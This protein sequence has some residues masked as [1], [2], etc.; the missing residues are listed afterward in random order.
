MGAFSG[1]P[2]GNSLW[3][4]I[5]DVNEIKVNQLSSPYATKVYSEGGFYMLFLN[6]TQLQFARLIWTL[7]Q[8]YTELPG[9]YELLYL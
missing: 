8:L 2:N 4:I 9:T 5:K 7:Q 3:K 6:L 1:D